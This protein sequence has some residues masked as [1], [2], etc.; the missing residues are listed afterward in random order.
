MQQL[1]H[2]A[3]GFTFET[4]YSWL[5]HPWRPRLA[6][7]YGYASGDRN[8]ADADSNRFDRFFGFARPWSASD[9]ITFDNLKSPK[10][11]L[12]LQPLPSLRIDAGY[13][14]YSLASARDR[15]NNLLD[16]SPFNR[17]ASGQSGDHLG[18]ELDFRVR[19][20]L[21]EHL[22]ATLGYAHFHNGEFVAARQ[23]AFSG[24]ASHDSDFVYLELTLRLF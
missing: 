8:P 3:R 5:Q 18:N 13:S 7:F 14:R 24:S 22:D 10:L 15:F 12:E 4:G 17:D 11:R 6:F 20:S 16:G 9:Y 2:R 21:S 23:R 1:K 19:A